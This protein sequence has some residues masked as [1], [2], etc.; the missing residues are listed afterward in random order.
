MHGINSSVEKACHDHYTTA[1][2]VTTCNADSFH[3][4]NISSQKPMYSVC[5]IMPRGTNVCVSLYTFFLPL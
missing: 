2:M 1:N 4:G 5:F 3:N